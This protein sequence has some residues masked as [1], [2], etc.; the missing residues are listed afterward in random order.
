MNCPNCRCHRCKSYYRNPAP[1]GASAWASHMD[2]PPVA[3]EGPAT[4]LETSMTEHFL[5]PMR[6]PKFRHRPETT[7]DKIRRLHRA[8]IMSR[9]SG[10]PAQELYDRLVRAI[11]RTGMPVEY[12]FAGGL[13]PPSRENP[14]GYLD[15]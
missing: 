7:E 8:Y 10:V 13:Q 5:G 1:W 11:E 6:N 9:W 2:A 12:F 15:Y 4:S 14:W 3:N